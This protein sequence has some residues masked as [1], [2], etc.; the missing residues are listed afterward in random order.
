MLPVKGKEDIIG[1]CVSK[2]N[3]IIGFYRRKICPS[4]GVIRQCA[5]GSIKCSKQNL[6]G[7]EWGMYS[8]GYRI[9]QCKGEHTVLHLE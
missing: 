4:L 1:V 8:A 5:M 7:V 3:S 6:G 9:R 2:I